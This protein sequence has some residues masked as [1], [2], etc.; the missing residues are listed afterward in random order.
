MLG[1]IILALSAEAGLKKQRDDD[2]KDAAIIAEG[3]SFD[4]IGCTDCHQYRESDEDAIAPDLT[5]YGSREWL[6]AIIS[7]PGHERFYGS[8][9]DRMPAF[10]RDEKLTP[11]EINILADWL[12]E[13][14]YEKGDE[15]RPEPKPKKAQPEIAQKQIEEPE[16]PEPE[17]PEPEKPKP[18]TVEPNLAVDFVT[19]IKPILESRCLSCHNAVK[20]KGKF[21][22]A[23][24]QVAF[25]GGDSGLPSIVPGKPDESN[26]VKLVSLEEDH[27]D[28][29][30]SKGAPLTKEQIQAIRTW[31]AEG[32]HWPDGMEL[33]A[34]KK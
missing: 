32:A 3:Q 26:L 27:D 29:M 5:G 25:K 22:M 33:K 34:V 21:V 9:N 8:K 31:I 13:D 1:K 2:A 7:N 4:E 20:K 14:W 15:L 24:K 30:P 28:I 6:I 17:H 19:Q 18:D 16:Q 12:R 10:G 11:R 23:T